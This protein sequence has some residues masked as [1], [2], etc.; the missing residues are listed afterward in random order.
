MITLAGLAAL[1]TV[2]NRLSNARHAQQIS[3][4]FLG[5]S[6]QYG[7]HCRSR[8]DDSTPEVPHG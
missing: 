8:S 5:T 7:P 6:M 2:R 1:Q 3:L 4:S